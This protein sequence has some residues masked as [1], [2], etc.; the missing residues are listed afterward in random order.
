[1]TAEKYVKKILKNVHCSS[2]KKKDIQKQLLS[3][4]EERT[5]QGEAFLRG[6]I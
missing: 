4:M 1:M 3:D 6:C 2:A 5:S